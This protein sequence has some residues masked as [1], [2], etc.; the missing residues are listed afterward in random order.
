MHTVYSTVPQ[1]LY[2][3]E[4]WENSNGVDF[5]IVTT[6]YVTENLCLQKVYLLFCKEMDTKEYL[7]KSKFLYCVDLQNSQKLE[8]WPKGTFSIKGS[9]FERIKKTLK[10]HHKGH[11]VHKKFPFC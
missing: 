2:R 8:A 3:V 5:L 11:Y 4:Q 10:F 9:A 6:I 7:S 1:I